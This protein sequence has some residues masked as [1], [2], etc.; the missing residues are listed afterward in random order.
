MKLALV[1]T[2]NSALNSARS[3]SGTPKS[4]KS[5]TPRTERSGHERSPRRKSRRSDN[6]DGS[7]ENQMGLAGQS[8]V[9]NLQQCKGLPFLEKTD[10]LVSRTMRRKFDA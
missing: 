5:K 6:S 9:K 7:R 2:S 8:L 3:E 10:A 4:G 1:A